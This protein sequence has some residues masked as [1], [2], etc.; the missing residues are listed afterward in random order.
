MRGPMLEALARGW[1]VL[2]EKPFLLDAA[3]LEEVRARRGEL[4][5]MPVHN[6]KYAPVIRAAKQRLP[7]L[8]PLRRV[9]IQTLRME[10]AAAADS[11][12]WRRDPAIAGGGILLDHGWHSLYLAQHFFEAVPR[13][14]SAQLHRPAPGAAEDE[15]IVELEFAEGSA[16]IEL[17]WNASTRSNRLRFL[18][19]AGEML[20]ADGVLQLADET[21]IYPALSAGS[22]HP[23]W[24]AAMLPEVLAAFREPALAHA[25]FEEAAACLSLVQRAYAT[26]DWRSEALALTP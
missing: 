24:F 21:Q 8:G 7:E 12:N 9:E 10:D 14:I 5:V 17:S 11:S 3:V 1:H 16:R 23:E 20:L 4:A 26:A 13:E 2:C 15:A 18:G 22:H 19:D 25:S 6:W